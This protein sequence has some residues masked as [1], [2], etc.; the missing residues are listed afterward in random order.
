M[1]VENMI[2]T[3]WFLLSVLFQIIS[4]IIYHILYQILKIRDHDIKFNRC[5]TIAR[6]S[7]VITCIIITLIFILVIYLRRDLYE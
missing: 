2:I 6:I 4:Y 7:L 3:I 1:G 5:I